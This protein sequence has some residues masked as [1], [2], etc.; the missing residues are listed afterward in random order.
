MAAD[1]GEQ[2]TV[3]QPG[4]WKPRH[5]VIGGAVL[6]LLILAVRSCGGDADD[7]KV[8]GSESGDETP[9]QAIVVQIP[10]SQW[11]PQ[12]APAPGGQPAYQPPVYVQ[13]QAPL[14][15]ADSG[16]PW[17]VQ[18]QQ[19]AADA[20]GRN[21]GRQAQS[22]GWGQPQP[23]RPRYSQPPGTGQYRPLDEQQSRAGS[24][25]APTVAPPPLPAWPAA[26]YDRPAG[27]SF[28]ANGASPY[29]GAYP[30]YYGAAP[31][32]GP[33]GYGGRWPGAYGYGYPGIAGPGV[34]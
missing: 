23:Q 11:P 4:F 2:A 30:G 12:A 21:T 32:V 24:R 28:G 3:Q 5:A 13:P 34:W 26:P 25:S 14:P 27:S 9:R 16:N 17:A 18:R 29:A 8:A 1:N 31:Y 7:A 22:R 19:P 6:L 10:A 15:S 20:G 33:G